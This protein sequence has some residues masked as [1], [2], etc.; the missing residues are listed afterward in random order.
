MKRKRDKK[1]T[2]D[3][4]FIRWDKE[5]DKAI[6]SADKALEKMP[7]HRGAIMCKA[8][9]FIS[10]KKYPEATKELTYLINFLEDPI[11][12]NK[13]NNSDKKIKYHRS[14]APNIYK[15]LCKLNNKHSKEFI[16]N[17][18]ENKLYATL[19]WYNENI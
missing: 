10:Q 12:N 11:A 6:A 19:K 1:E 17:N 7:N 3:E 13:I 2:F 5:Y 8:L 18:F 15:L 9:V 14:G 16:K 4:K